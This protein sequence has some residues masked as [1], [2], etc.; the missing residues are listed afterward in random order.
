VQAMALR[1]PVCMHVQLLERSQCVWHWLQLC[2]R[3]GLIAL[4][5]HAAV[6]V[7][8]VPLV[9]RPGL[10]CAMTDGC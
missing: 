7:R 3:C 8:G 6:A 2:D 10:L 4:Q 9:S 5:R 1:V